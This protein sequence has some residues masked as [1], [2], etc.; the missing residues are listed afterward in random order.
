MGTN[1]RAVCKGG[2]GEEKLE[3]G[4]G[5]LGRRGAGGGEGRG[6]KVVGKDRIRRRR[7]RRWQLVAVVTEGGIKTFVLPS[8]E[9]VKTW[10]PLLFIP[11]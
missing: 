7:R 9:L 5:V 3:G 8:P 11:S 10:P 6:G 4:L 2:E 1:L